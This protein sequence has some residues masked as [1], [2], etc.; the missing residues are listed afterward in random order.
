MS[1]AQKKTKS[2][3]LLER[4]HEIRRSE[5]KDDIALQQIVREAKLLAEIDPVN[6]EYIM[7]AVACLRNQIPAMRRHY[8]SAIRQKPDVPEP[9]Y[10]Y[11]NSLATLGW[12]DEALA[13]LD[14]ALE[15]AP[16]YDLAKNLKERI[17]DLIEDQMWSDMN[18]DTEEDLR[19]FCMSTTVS[20][21]RDDS[22]EVT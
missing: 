8:T 18:N 13:L 4:V 12:F 5:K 6:Y 7:G 21:E 10:N 3:Q 20:I 19:N 9:Y 14:K 15:L 2:G 11:A 17:L 1:Q 16:S 22:C